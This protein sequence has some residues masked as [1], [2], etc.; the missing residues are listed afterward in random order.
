MEE[1]KEMGERNQPYSPDRICLF[2]QFL[3]LL[4]F[5]VAIIIACFFF[6]SVPFSEK[7]E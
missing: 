7:K 4:L 2:A 6:P 5:I 1:T 3:P